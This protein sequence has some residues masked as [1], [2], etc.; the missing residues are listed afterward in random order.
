VLTGVLEKVYITIAHGEKRFVDGK[1]AVLEASS[2]YS[3]FIKALN[4][5]IAIETW[6]KARDIQ[7]QLV[8]QETCTGLLRCLMIV[9]KKRKAFLE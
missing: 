2:A 7:A 3:E 5:K 1:N 4:T 6:T 9:D 8:E